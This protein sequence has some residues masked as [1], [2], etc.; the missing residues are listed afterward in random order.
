MVPFIT[1][2]WQKVN[3]FFNQFYGKAKETTGDAYL[4][5]RLKNLAEAGKIDIQ[6][7]VKNMKEM[8]IRLKEF[9]NEI[10]PDN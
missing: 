4:L 1:K 2:D 9:E 7:N 10:A 6:R 5:W 3:K 8:E